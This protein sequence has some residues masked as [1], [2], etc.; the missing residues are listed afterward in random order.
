MNSDKFFD[1]LGQMFGSMWIFYV[2]IGATLVAFG[3]LILLVPRLLV[4]LV[5][6]SVIFAGI[7]LIIVGLRLRAPRKLSELYYHD[8]FNY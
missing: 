1:P 4:L 5:A 3:V 8:P 2:I 6:S 7:S